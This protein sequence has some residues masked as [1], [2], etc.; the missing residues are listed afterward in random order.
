MIT[1]K[2]NGQKLYAEAICV[3]CKN[4]G[5]SKAICILDDVTKNSLKVNWNVSNFSKHVKKHGNKSSL[6]R[7][8]SRNDD[9]VDDFDDNLDLLENS[10]SKV[11]KIDAAKLH[12][13]QNDFNIQKE[14]NDPT[15]MV[16]NLDYYTK[17][18]YDQISK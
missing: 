6:K 13:T 16:E 15:G 17:I 2:N 9:D 5:E 10:I 14:V 1:I 8:N 11:P 4:S 3:L 7:K 12:V 18:I